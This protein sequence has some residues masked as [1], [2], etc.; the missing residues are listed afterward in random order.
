MLPKEPSHCAQT[1]RRESGRAITSLLVFIAIIATALGVVA[2]IFG[3][4]VPVGHVGVRKIAFGPGQGLVTRP[5]QPGFHWTIPVYSTVYDVPQTIQIIDFARDVSKNQSSFGSLDI[6][7]I[8]GTT[9]DIDAAILYRF[10]A[11]AGT[12]DGVKH[13]GAQDL[14]NSVGA[15]D[16]Q[17]RKYLSQVAENELKRALSAL[18]TVDFYD[19][20]AREDRVKVAQDQL[21]AALAP[22]GVKVDAVLVRRYTYR[23]EI[24]QA[25]FKKNLQELE[26][27]Y[28]KV[29]G[30]FAAARRD[31]NKVESDGNVQIQN[32]EKQGVG[33]AEQI[34]SEGDLYRRE[35]MA[36]GS[37]LV[38]EAKANVDK[39]KSEVL[40]KVG[41][42]VYVALQL[43]QSL[44]SLK[45][46][47][48]ANVDPYDFDGW[49]KRLA[50][51]GDR[52]RLDTEDSDAKK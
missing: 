12:T 14:I 2:F 18:S 33:E 36:Q 34:R 13:G 28:N 41:S 30:E 29:A 25:I 32:L 5:L 31:V 9:V 27:A 48:V 4:I 23:A 49:V 11:Q 46:G 1:P 21:Q 7:T 17:W 6:P 35:K 24:D 37:L 50:G 26:S 39:Q 15:T 43:A 10:Y 16:V 52:A 45:G 42:D 3:T 20:K 44:A 40:S 22:V 19:P 8:D 47:V 38:A 51:A